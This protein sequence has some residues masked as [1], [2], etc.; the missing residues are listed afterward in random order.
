M[1]Q[2]GTFLSTRGIQEEKR[3]ESI[4]NMN[5]NEC[6]RVI[7]QSFSHPWME[8]PQHYVICHGVTSLITQVVADHY[9]TIDYELEGEARLNY[10]FIEIESEY[11]LI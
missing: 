2:E 8:I 10:R 11:I 5:Y 4:F 1:F 3:L 6:T 9:L 7:Y